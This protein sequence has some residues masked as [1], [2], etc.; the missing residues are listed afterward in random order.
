MDVPRKQI[1]P[2]VQLVGQ[3]DHADF[4]NSI[5]LLRATAQLTTSP[6]RVTELLIVAQSMPYAISNSTIQNLR[7]V[8]PLAGVIGLLGSWCEGETRTG[9]PWPGI[10]RLFWYDFPAWWQR[11]LAL[12]SA[13]RCPD[14]AKPYDGAHANRIVCD[15]GREPRRTGSQSI[16]R[17]TSGLI[18]LSAALRDTAGALADVVQQAGYATVW[19]PPGRRMVAVRGA[20]AGIWEG[21]QLSESEENSLAAFSEFLARDS[22]PVIALLDFPRS[23]RCVRAQELGAAAVLGKQ[24]RNPNLLAT[25]EQFTTGTRANEGLTSHAA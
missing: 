21:G 17:R 20:R 15:S 1:R 6:D 23:D 19:Q 18:V 5:E 4:H 2:R 10:D 13:A 7:R 24:W 12:R 14:W 16:R 11:Q 25:I 22:A 8:A 3:W 9:R